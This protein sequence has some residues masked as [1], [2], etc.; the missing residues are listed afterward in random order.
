M[1]ELLRQVAR[2]AGE[3]KRRFNTE[4]LL[5]LHG[6]LDVNNVVLPIY[7]AADL[8][9]IPPPVNSAQFEVRSLSSSVDDLHSQPSAMK[10]QIEKPCNVILPSSSPCVSHRRLRSYVLMYHHLIRPWPIH[11]DLQARL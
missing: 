7:V 5:Q 3:N 10:Q 2:K 8:S 1:E 6:I 4:E 9:C 11:L